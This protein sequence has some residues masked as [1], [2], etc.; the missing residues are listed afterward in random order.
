MPSLCT[1]PLV[2]HRVD[3]STIHLRPRSAMTASRALGLNSCTAIFICLSDALTIH[4]GPRRTV[5]TSR[6]PE[7][8]FRTNISIYTWLESSTTSIPPNIASSSTRM[9]TF[10]G[11]PTSTLVTTGGYIDH[12]VP[13]WLQIM[14]PPRTPGTTFRDLLLESAS[15]YPVDRP[16]AQ[17]KQWLPATTFRDQIIA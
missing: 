4:L 9:P 11:P 13:M 7:L 6:T 12:P 5:A 14:S 17:E 15:P 16:H 1:A 2:S 3:I 10:S 8:N